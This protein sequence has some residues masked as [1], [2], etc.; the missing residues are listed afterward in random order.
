MFKLCL[1]SVVVFCASLA[2]ANVPPAIPVINE[3]EFDGQ[4]VNPSD[5]HMECGPFMDAD[6]GDTH[7]CSNW[8]VW[9]E[10]PAERIWT[11]NCIGGVERV[12]THLG[13]GV[14]MG[15]HAGR[16][17][18]LHDTD[19]LLRV[20]HRDSSGDGATEWSNWAN[21]FFTTTSPTAI[22][23]LELDD[24][25]DSP[26]PTWND[27]TGL[28]Y[29]L[30]TAS[31]QPSLT[32]ESPVGET[33]LRI[34]GFDGSSNFLT[35]PA[36]IGSHEPARVRLSPGSFSKDLVMPET[37]LT[38]T[39][40]EGNEVTVYIP[41]V[42]IAPGTD[43]LYWIAESGATYTATEGQTEPDFSD[44]V[45]GAPVPWAVRQ[46]G[47]V[48]EVVASGFQL[49]VNIAFVPNPGPNPEDPLYYVTEL[50][51]TIK[52]VT[53]AGVVSDYVTGLL[54]FNP[55]GNFPG[56]G[57]QGLT[58]IVVDPVTGDVFAGYLRDPGGPHYPRISRF[59][60]SDGGLTADNETV[61]LDMFGETQG[62]SHQIS[63]FSF[64]PDGKLYVHMGDGFDASTGQ[65]LNSY[66]GKVLRL[67]LDGSA[68]TDNPFYNAGNGID[69]RDYIFAYGLRNPF[70]GAWRPSTNEHYAVE[71]GPSVD[72]MMVIDEGINY[73]WDGSNES[74]FNFALYNWDPAHAPTNM[75]FVDPSIFDGSGFPAWAQD[76]AFVT[77]SGPTYATGPQSRGKRV[78]EFELAPDGTVISGPNT[79]V[80]YVS[81]GKA[82][83]VGIAAGPDGLYFTDL[84]KDQDYAS[85]I[86]RGAQVLRIR[87]VG[88]ADFAATPT[89]GAAPLLVDFT[90]LSTVPNPT[91]WL[92]EFGDGTTST[93]QH[94]SHT[95]ANDGIYDVRLTV[96]GDHGIR[97]TQKPGFVRVGVPVRVAIIGGNASPSA[98][99]AA[100]ATHL[101]Q[102]GF[103]VLVY[104]DE[105]GNRPNATTLAAEYDIVVISST[106]NSGNVAG[107]FVGVPVP[108]VFWEQALLRADRMGLAESGN[109]VGDV[110]A[111][112]ILEN[113]HPITTG[114]GVGALSVFSAP[115][116]MSVGF[117]QYAP[118]ATVLATRAGAT[119]D[120][121]IIAAEVGAQLLGGQTAPD[122]RVF[123]F[124]EDNSWLTATHHG[125]H[126][127]EN[128]VCWAAGLVAPSVV[129]HPL[130]Q[131]VSIGATVEFAV[132]ASGSSPLAY[133]WRRNGITIP[134][135]GSPTL[136]L[137]DVQTADA[138]MY[139]VVVS[140][141]C[142][143]VISQSATLTVNACLADFNGDTQVDFFDVQSFLQAF[144]A[145]DPSANIVPDGVFDFFDVQAFLG[146]FSAGCP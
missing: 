29:I 81:N 14:F 9:T 91:A 64:G 122:R 45:R 74:M 53:N 124:F 121:T 61:L 113:T 27:T 85:P 104:D 111:I 82:T 34:D 16:S 118:G 2:T 87:F 60:S 131:T 12:H 141:P 72:R 76:R 109:T 58:G 51:G 39:T 117:S 8:E 18:L 127:L 103:E 23:P 77:E 67:N 11:I 79:L 54:N 56:S 63:N 13:D 40:D 6:P 71:N 97:V 92:W 123:L 89:T 128:A 138:G 78:I 59:S 65:N 41:S 37:D 114:H 102:L 3:P 75:T 21:R 69:S 55:T 83:A 49:P 135:A 70:G 99:D 107:E 125:Q 80:E 52:V 112:S 88:D 108:V 90:D 143:E 93:A 133:T 46:S 10:F 105:P 30:P 137:T 57:E 7:L 145:E 68:P 139:D 62:Q 130:D 24:I 28:P 132:T 15:S 146:I 98:S 106:T 20:R 48:V 129:D 95:Y 144:A 33:I 31:T 110:T 86:D 136:T 66:R 47:Y 50:Y 17:E 1:L 115:S 119:G 84:Y 35:N 44:L 4:L 134:N 73:L 140:N 120:A 100:I 25:V 26:S 43:R 22:N 142:G 38:F 5:V 42:R 94:P 101:G 126:L 116:T 36:S 32:I 96:T 19:Y